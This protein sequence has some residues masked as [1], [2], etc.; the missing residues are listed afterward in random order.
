MSK[1]SGEIKKEKINAKRRFGGG[2]GLS[3]SGVIANIYLYI[4]VL[5]VLV[6]ICQQND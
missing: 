2:E 1:T 6:E 4:Q 5:N 3:V